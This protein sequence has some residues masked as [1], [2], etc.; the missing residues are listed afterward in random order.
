[1]TM[2]PTIRPITAP[3]PPEAIAADADTGVS[4]SAGATYHGGLPTCQWG[5]MSAPVY[6]EM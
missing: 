5:S 1:M 4:S 6:S 3:G 2:A